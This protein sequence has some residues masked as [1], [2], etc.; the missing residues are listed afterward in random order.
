MKNPSID[1]L[2]RANPAKE[3]KIFEILDCDT[4]EFIDSREFISGHT[5]GEIF[6][7][8]HE[9]RLRWKT[10]RPK[11]VCS[12]C[13]I[14]VSLLAGM[15]RNWFFFRHLIEDGRCA[16]RTRG[17][18]NQKQINAIR[19]DCLVES[20][21]HKRFKQLMYDCLCADRSF[22]DEKIEQVRTSTT[23]KGKRRK[24]DASAIRNDLLHAFEVQLSS[25]FF[26]VVLE[27]Q[28]FYRGEGA[29][30]VW[31]LPGFDPDDR[32]MM[33]D[34]IF[35]HNNCN[36]MVLNE[37]TASHSIIAERLHFDCWYRMPSS[38]G[39]TYSESWQFECVPFDA[40]TIDIERQRAFY[41]DYE[42]EKALVQ[43]AIAEHELK[44]AEQEVAERRLREEKREEERLAQLRSRFEEFWLEH[45]RGK[46][47]TAQAW[48]DLVNSN[49]G[50]YDEYE[51]PFGPF[52][53]AELCALLNA[54]YWAK[55]L[56][57]VDWEFED[58]VKVGHHVF[59]K[60][61]QHFAIFCHC[62]WH[63]KRLEAVKSADGTGKFRAKIQAVR[64]ATTQE[65]QAFEIA[66]NHKKLIEL[67]FPGPYQGFT[68]WM[69]S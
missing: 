32:T 48:D 43:H 28:S 37:T 29:I 31:V 36:V 11:F 33:E 1:P 44:L 54:L 19:Y 30:L 23:T 66:P 26:D 21:P 2:A 58:V 57:Q 35:F 15:E 4:G 17:E 67:L 56:K 49:W 20:E 18:M 25:T 60:H 22:S 64:S 53:D 41:F 7:P 52:A 68:S 6:E 62:L 34:D 46:A 8:R 13:K 24:P 12:D 3:L 10:D 61:K 55:H 47:G 38:D 14:S 40:L 45:A 69:A 39:S 5:Y 16:A 51:L 9:V 59:D 63:F 42:K 50:A 27:R 65:K